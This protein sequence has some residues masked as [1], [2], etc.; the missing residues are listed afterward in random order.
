MS[1]HRPGTPPAVRGRRRSTVAEV[2][3][4]DRPAPSPR[5]SRTCR[6]R[7][8]PPSVR[9]ST[10]SA[11]QRS[12][13][14]KRGAVQSLRA[15]DRT[16]SGAGR[17]AGE[18]RSPGVDRGGHARY[19]ELS[20]ARRRH[21]RR[22]DHDLV[23]AVV[24][25]PAEGRRH[26]RT[27]LTRQPEGHRCRSGRRRS[28][29]SPADWTDGHCHGAGV[30]GAHPRLAQY[31]DL[32]LATE[33]RMGRDAVGTRRLAGGSDLLGGV[34]RLDPTGPADVRTAGWGGCRRRECRGPGFPTSGA[35]RGR[36]AGW[37]AGSRRRPGLQ[38][39]GLSMARTR[40]TWGG[41]TDRTGGAAGGG[42][43]AWARCCRVQPGP[44]GHR[45]DRTVL[46]R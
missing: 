30:V 11:I 16:R 26:G 10:G 22:P 34:E 45:G 19:R 13:P 31:G 3:V 33:D 44:V 21:H 39:A 35:T 23:V 42:D 1:R 27:A 6:N 43:S 25:H 9:S 38:L 14:P 41:R 12:S 5:R 32:R 2:A 37:W 8:R 46:A 18:A 20:V 36:G 17:H 28:A 24:D 4:S 40:R 15:R 29:T 7:R